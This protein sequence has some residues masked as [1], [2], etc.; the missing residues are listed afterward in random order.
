MKEERC[1]QCA[2]PTAA[3]DAIHYG[4]TERGSRLLCSQCFNAEVAKQN[5]LAAFENVRL[6]P[7]RMVDCTQEEHQFHFQPVSVRNS[8]RALRN[9]GT[10]DSKRSV[11]WCAA[12]SAFS[13]HAH[14][15]GGLAD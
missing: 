1:E 7:V 10:A 15:R 3:W 2:R 6:E 8:E 9:S 11:I 4:S 14:L 12:C 5:G 13:R